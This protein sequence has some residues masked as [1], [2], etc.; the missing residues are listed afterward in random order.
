MAYDE[1]E[2]IEHHNVTVSIN[3]SGSVNNTP[4][5]P[6]LHNETA[7]LE[8]VANPGWTFDS[9]S[10]ADAGDL[11]DNANGTWD[12]VMDDDKAVTAVFIQDEYTLT[13][14]SDH[15]TVASLPDRLT[16]FYGEEVLLTVSP[17]S[18]WLFT[19]WSGDLTGSDNPNSILM[20]SDKNVTAEYVEISS[21]CRAL[22]LGHTGKGSN[23]AAN[24]ANSTGCPP[25][26]Y[27]HNESISL[28]GAYPDT[29]WHII[30]WMGTNNN[31]S[32]QPSNTVTMPDSD[33]TAK[34]NYG[35]TCYTLTISHTGEGSN[36]VAY[37]SNSAGC[38]LGRY[39]YN[40]PISLTGASPDTGWYIAGWIGTENNDSTDSSNKINMP[41][42]HHSC[43]VLYLQYNDI[44][45]LPFV[46]N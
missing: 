44:I 14:T 43:E 21:D 45:F 46:F 32:T 5:N 22:S 10:G 3:G 23:P 25:G 38:L 41:A 40:D 9:W 19:G 27:Y 2:T 16:Y 39:H 7:T 28:T 11:I 20:D 36:P 31:S 30:S 26:W 35:Q 24:P 33:H 4:G 34:V 37:P 1:L 17:D 6:Y 13:I 42:S 18:G 12:L 8:P 29:G 15:G